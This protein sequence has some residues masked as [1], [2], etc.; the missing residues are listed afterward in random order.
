MTRREWLELAALAAPTAA[1]L[2]AAEGRLPDF[3]GWLAKA[4]LI[5]DTARLAIA[6]AR[7][8]KESR[9]ALASFPDIARAAAGMQDSSARPSDPKAL[10]AWLGARIARH[11]AP[12]WGAQEDAAV[13]K[14]RGP[15]GTASKKDF[16]VYL[17]AIEYRCRIAFHTLAPAENDIHRW[18]EG[19]IRWSRAISDYKLKLAAALASP[20]GSAFAS[21][22]DPLVRAALS[23]RS[24]RIVTPG[25]LASAR[26]STPYGKALAAALQSIQA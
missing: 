8:P 10:S 25:T 2:R 9:S 16:E 3:S 19:I 7:V 15:Q 21:T 26:P 1:Q 23:I 14:L 11:A 22:S 20:P 24:G 12:E 17:T 4:A 6:G 18:L 5:D 13:L